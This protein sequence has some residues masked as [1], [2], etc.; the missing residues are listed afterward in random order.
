M[1]GKEIDLEGV[2][3]AKRQVCGDRA[4][5]RLKELPLERDV[6]KVVFRREPDFHSNETMKRP[7]RDKVRSKGYFANNG[8]ESH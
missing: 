4:V 2:G 7:F 6:R 8:T 1:E 5:G 3:G